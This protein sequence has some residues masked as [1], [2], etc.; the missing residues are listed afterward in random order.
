MPRLLPHQSQ[1]CLANSA[2]CLHP[3]LASSLQTERVDTRLGLTPAAAPE[4]LDSPCALP[5]PAATLAAR[6]PAPEGRL[7]LPS[8][9]KG[10]QSQQYA[11]LY[12]ICF[13][14]LSKSSSVLVDHPEAH[15][16]QPKSFLS[17][18]QALHQQRIQTQ[19]TSND[20][21]LF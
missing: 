12:I 9:R 20:P 1:P 4:L 21:V 3:G 6:S 8:R 5:V 19:P 2:S 18:Q 16:N 14:S 7:V 17:P 15:R 11:P 10:N 13:N